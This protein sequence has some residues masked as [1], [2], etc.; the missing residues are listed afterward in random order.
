MN[1]VKTYQE[2]PDFLLFMQ[3]QIA[4]KRQC[5]KNKTATN[6]CAAYRSFHSFLQLR[7]KRSTLRFSEIT[8]ELIL[9]YEKYLLHDRKIKRNSSSFYI[10]SLRS[11]FRKGIIAYG[12]LHSDPFNRVYAGVDT[13]MKRA[14]NL[15]VIIRL[16]QYILPNKSMELSRDAFVFCFLARGMA[17]IDLAKLQK[18]DI[19]NGRLSYYRSKTGRLISVKIE[20][21][22]QEIINKYSH[23]ASCFLFPILKTARFEQPAYETALRLHN[24]NLH[25][26]SR[27]LGEGI[28]LTSYVPRHSWAT[29]ASRLHI[30]T[31]IISESMGHSNEK[32]TSI[33]LSSIDYHEI[34]SANR[35]IINRIQ[36]K[37]GKKRKEKGIS[38]SI[39]TQSLPNFYYSVSCPMSESPAPNIKI[40]FKVTVS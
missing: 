20:R 22:M 39:L 30:P 31:R 38:A 14:V 28:S 9:R 11:V 17:F 8:D 24:H 33:Y 19:Q 23:T 37:K 35:K 13:T 15:D 25:K 10:R 21:R 26:L 12:L 18:S 34:D 7:E 4:E 29:E 5:G 36:D 27:L 40:I 1:K 16:S 3:R 32:T 6:Y 2:D